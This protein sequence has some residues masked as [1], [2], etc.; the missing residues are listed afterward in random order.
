MPKKI[1]LNEI[2]DGRTG[3]GQRRTSSDGRPVDDI[4]AEIKKLY[5]KTKANTIERDFDRA[6]DL[7]KMMPTPDDRQRATVY[8]EGLAEM[9]KDWKRRKR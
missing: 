5:F 3:S 8:M 1:I 7:L 4:L 2:P 6:I 9:R